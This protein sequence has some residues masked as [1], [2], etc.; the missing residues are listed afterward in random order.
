MMHSRVSNQAHGARRPEF[1]ATERGHSR[2]EIAAA[3]VGALRAGVPASEL[4]QLSVCLKGAIIQL[5]INGSMAVR[6]VANKVA[7]KSCKLASP[8]R[9]KKACVLA[10]A[11]GHRPQ[12]TPRR[13]STD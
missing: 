8:K 11:T 5:Y 4:L 7:V 6:L 13:N 1:R 12:R 3:R 10:S 9:C 2:G